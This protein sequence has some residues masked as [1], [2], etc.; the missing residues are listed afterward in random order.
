[1]NPLSWQTSLIDSEVDCILSSVGTSRSSGGILANKAA[2]V[3]RDFLRRGS[4]HT[5]TGGG[6]TREREGEAEGGQGGGTRRLDIVSGEV[7]SI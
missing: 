2:P 6:K 7:R 1:M 4:G 3:K 5:S